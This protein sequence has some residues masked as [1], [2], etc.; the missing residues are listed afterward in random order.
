MSTPLPSPSDTHPDRF[1]LAMA[2]SGIGMA[3][4]DLDGRWLEVN[5]ALERMLGYRAD[6]LIGRPASA[7]THPDEVEPSR[8][9][10]TDLVDGRI[11]VIDAPQRY[12]HRN[13]E[14]VWVYANVAAMR[15]PH[16]APQSLLLQLRDLTAQRAAE[17]RVETH[18]AERADALAATQQQLQLFVDA[19]SHDLR[20]PLRS[21]ESFSALLAERAQA[22]LDDTDRDYLVRIRA[23]AQRMSGLLGALSELSRATRAELKPAQVDLSLLAEWVCAEL[24]DAD[25]E[26][27]AQVTVQP[28][29]QGWGDERLL[30]LLLTQL[31]DNAW[32]FSRGHDPIRI[33]VDGEREGDTVRMRVS[34][35]GHGF[36]MRYAHKLFT[37]F[38]R[39]HGPEQGGGHGLGL[40]IAQRVAQRHDGRILAQ[41]EP[42]LGSTFTL[43]MPAVAAPAARTPAKETSDA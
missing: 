21:I 15:D 10:I 11:A 20:A 31:L 27:H 26:Q 36:D 32:K 19:V 42:E 18:A 25:P 28:G 16:G 22:R 14:V 23:A 39:L 38:Q 24:H 3:I 12:L 8:A 34:D 29:L 2:A 1:Q 4:V 9:A 6:E 35:H 41:S 13:G 40:A 37:P 30:K 33:E 5:P 43:E 7:V 17:S